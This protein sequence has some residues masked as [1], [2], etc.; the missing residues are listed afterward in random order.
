MRGDTLVGNPDH[1]DLTKAEGPRPSGPLGPGG[2]IGAQGV[3]EAV[4][5]ANYVTLDM[6]GR[7]SP[8]KGHMHQAPLGCAI[9]VR[10]F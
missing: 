9:P 8:L 4:G 6:R 7:R 10:P 5:E 1:A 2:P 3:V